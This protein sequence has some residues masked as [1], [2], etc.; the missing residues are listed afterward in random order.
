MLKKNGVNYSMSIPAVSRRK[1]AKARLENQ[2]KIG[3]KLN[4]ENQVVALSEKDITRIKKEI[5]V[6]DLRIK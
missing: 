4:K 1:S 5:E 2:L 6:L 3:K